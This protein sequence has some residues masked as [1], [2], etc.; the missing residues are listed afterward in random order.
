MWLSYWSIALCFS[1]AVGNVDTTTRRATTMTTTTRKRPIQ[2]CPLIRTEF[3]VEIYVIHKVR[4]LHRIH[5]AKYEKHVY[6]YDSKALD[7]HLQNGYE[8]EGIIGN[9]LAYKTYEKSKAMINCFCPQLVTLYKFKKGARE[10]FYTKSS[11]EGWENTGAFM[12]VSF[13]RGYCGAKKA[14]YLDIFAAGYSTFHIGN[15]QFKCE[16]LCP[17][18]LPPFQLLLD[19]LY[20]TDLAEYR[21]WHFD[22]KHP[23][24]H[25]VAFYIW[26]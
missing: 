24:K 12:K 22:L 3:G 11:Y 19:V 18:Y 25:G 1:L 17:S 23:R 8:E 20:T 7:E 4:A 21:S 14:V 13:T 6:V 10:A 15:S 5:D 2:Y 26:G 16:T 9:V